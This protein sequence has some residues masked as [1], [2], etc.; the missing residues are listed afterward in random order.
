[1]S[2]FH[3]LKDFSAKLLAHCSTRDDACCCAPLLS[4]TSVATAVMQECQKT[5]APSA[6]LHALPRMTDSSVMSH[7]IS[8]IA[9]MTA[10]VEAGFVANVASASAL[11]SSS[12]LEAALLAPWQAS[13]HLFADAPNIQRPLADVSYHACISVAKLYKAVFACK[14]HL[15]AGPRLQASVTRSFHEFF[16]VHVLRPSVPLQLLSYVSR[17]QNAYYFFWFEFFFAAGTW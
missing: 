1:M 2:H 15:K 12:V 4:C 13:T 6:V 7:R 16:R 14:K 3:W 10:L 11:T 17:S 9:C 5:Q 8:A